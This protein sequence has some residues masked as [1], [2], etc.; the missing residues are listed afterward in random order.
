MD[1]IVFVCHVR[2][3]ALALAAA[4]INRW[5]ESPPKRLT[6]HSDGGVGRVSAVDF[7]GIIPYGLSRIER[8]TALK[9]EYTP[10][11]KTANILYRAARQGEGGMGQPG[12]V[13]ADAELVPPGLRLN[14]DFQ[15]TVR[16]DQNEVWA[17]VDDLING[18]VP[19]PGV[20]A[21]E[22]GH[23]VGLGHAPMGSNDLMAPMIAKGV[24]EFGKWS[25]QEFERRGYI[26]DVVEPTGDLWETKYQNGQLIVWKNK[27]L[28]RMTDS[29]FS[30]KKSG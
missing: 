22:T 27:V 14:S 20:I 29:P 13:L 7:R 1:E 24:T 21:H 9:F 6:W 11:N 10:N 18:K 2:S 30:A 15:G 23:I 5:P 4:G 8:V 26:V 16:F 25:L 28:Q 12:N 17:S 19:M 3:E